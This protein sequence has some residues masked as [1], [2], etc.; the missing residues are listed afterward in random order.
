MLLAYAALAAMVGM[1]VARPWPL[2]LVLDVI[3][4]RKAT[5][6][7][8]VPIAPALFDS[9]DRSTLL[10]LLCVA[11]VCMSLLEAFFGYLQKVWFAS[12]GQYASTDVLEHV[13]THLQT[14]PRSTHDGPRTGD[15]VVRLTSDVKTLRDLMVNHVEKLGRYAL[16]FVSTIA[17]MTWMNWRLTLLGLTVVPLVYCA[18]Y[19]FS[20]EIRRA[21]KQKRSREGA[22]ASIVQETLASLPEV[23]AFTQ[24]DS[25]R[26]R[27][28]REARQSLDAG[29]ESSRLGGAFTRSIK[30]LNTVGTALVVW[31][32]ATRVLHG[33]LSPGDLVV[34]VAYV[35]ELYEPIQNLSELWVQFAEAAVS[36][37]RVL[38]LIKTAPRIQDAPH[39]IRAPS[40][41]GEIRFDNVVFGYERD[42]PVLNQMSFRIA[43]GETVA[44]VGASG[45]G[46][47]T[48]LNL[49]LRFHDPWQGRVLIDGED[50][51]RFK[52]RSLRSQVSAVFQEPVLF[53]RT[54][55]ENIAYG[56][57]G[58]I[59]PEIVEAAKTAK[60]H[61]FI[62]ALPEGYETVLDERGGNLSGGQR[63]RIALARA[64]LR[65]API[66]I[67][68]E[69]TS[70]LDALTQSQLSETL[71]ELARARTTIVIAHRLSTV[72]RANRILVLQ[73]GH[74][75]EHGSHADLLARS[76]LYR[77]LWEAG[78]VQVE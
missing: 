22:V 57:A 20:R 13:F 45:S 65:D 10:A 63:Q 33:T 43:A 12:V 71:E 49:L 69:P 29:L 28:R 53:R 52:L 46:K 54:V 67:L 56:K 58:S 73:D 62:L 26:D 3:I 17:I 24:E 11:L 50:V 6:Q 40:F 30:V 2:K 25:E 39:A 1:A 37:E 51:R 32:G 27:F 18:S 14:L 4:L 42:T 41:R 19:W 59:M 34:F 36:G 21:V 55:A 66:L 8:T 60:A 48:V 76:G 38:D 23:Q 47:S 16:T 9:L 75:A 68:D 74:V 44:L 5:L 61:E 78:P 70:G 31:Y 7:E 15:I 77:E 35:R 72:E 64:F